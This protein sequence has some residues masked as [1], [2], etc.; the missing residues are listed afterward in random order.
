MTTSRVCRFTGLA[1][2]LAAGL[3]DRLGAGLADRLVAGL[4]DR[5][6]AGLAACL[7][8]AGQ[9]GLQVQLVAAVALLDGRPH[10][11]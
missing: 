10:L 11:Q 5:L 1:V 2:D 6:G 7:P 4:A 8:N 9:P 3:A